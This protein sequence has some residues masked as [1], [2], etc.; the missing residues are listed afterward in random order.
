LFVVDGYTLTFA[1][2]LR[3]G[4]ALANRNGARAVDVAGL[5]AFVAMSALCA[6]AAVLAL[7]SGGSASS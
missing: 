1:A 4:G 7:R 6:A 2:L 5:A 3:A